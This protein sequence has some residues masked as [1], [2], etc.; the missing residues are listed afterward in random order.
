MKFSQSEK[1]QIISTNEQEREHARKWLRE[2]PDYKIEALVLFLY[3]MPA[4]GTLGVVRRMAFL[5]LRTLTEE[6]FRQEE[7]DEEDQQG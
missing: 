1:L 2:T 7:R 6:S 4:D 3:G 5:A